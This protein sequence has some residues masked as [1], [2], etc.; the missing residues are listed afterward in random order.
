MKTG[1]IIL[2]DS[3]WG[4]EEYTHFKLGKGIMINFAPENRLPRTWNFKDM[5]YLSEYFGTQDIDWDNISE[6]GMCDTCDYGSRYGLEVKIFN[7]TKNYPEL[8]EEK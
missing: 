3:I 5:L 2:F 8:I 6:R 7:I 1:Q 4:I